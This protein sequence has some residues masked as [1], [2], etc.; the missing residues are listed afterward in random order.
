M[1]A[2]RPSWAAYQAV[3][4]NNLQTQ[5]ALVS[6]FRM[7]TLSDTHAWR[8]NTQP[9]AGNQDTKA[10]TDNKNKEPEILDELRVDL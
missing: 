9:A 5:A 6:S 3:V 10:I 7:I 8:A 2:P 4:L 1:R